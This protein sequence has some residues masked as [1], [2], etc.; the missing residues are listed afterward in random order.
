LPR[1]R[2]KR[3]FYAKNHSKHR[4]HYRLLIPSKKE[5]RMNITTVVRALN[6]KAVQQG[7][8]HFCDPTLS[9]SDPIY[10]RFLSLWRSKAAS[11]PM[12]IKSEISPRDLKGFLSNIVI[13]HRVSKR[14]SSYIWRLV[15]SNVVQ[16]VG[17]ITGKTFEDSAPS[18]NVA[19]WIECCD[20]VLDG[21]QPMRFLGRVHLTGREYLGAENVF[22]P[23]ANDEGQPTF[24]MGM[25]RYT[26]RHSDDE[27]SWKLLIASIGNGPL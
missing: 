20:L 16:I 13:C 14:P 5:Q 17:H 6:Q 19:R 27:E 26:P 18:E 11:R 24:V 25:C 9:F 12:P 3:I 22:V 1:S 4:R 10:E 15:G 23:L 21:G 2:S 8:H 7:V